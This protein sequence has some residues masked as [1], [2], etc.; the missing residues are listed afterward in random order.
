MPASTVSSIAKLNRALRFSAT[1]LIGRS[2]FSA[3]SSLLEEIADLGQQ[4][5]LARRLRRRGG[6]SLVLALQRIHETD[7]DEQH[8]GDD[9]EIDRQRQEIAPR[10]H[11]ALDRK[12]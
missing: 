12:S 11:R 4:F 6:C 1:I 9:H 3:T 8:K 7:D 2:F 10:Q 5:F